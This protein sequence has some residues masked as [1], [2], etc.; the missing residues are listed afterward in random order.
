LEAG[1]EWL[2]NLEGCPIHFNLIQTTSLS[3]KW[4]W[5]NTKLVARSDVFPFKGPAKVGGPRLISEEKLQNRRGQILSFIGTSGLS[6]TQKIII[7]VVPFISLCIL[8]GGIW[9]SWRIHWKR[10][11]EREK[12]KADRNMGNDTPQELCGDTDM[13]RH[14]IGVNQIPVEGDYDSYLRELE[15]SNPAAKELDSPDRPAVELEGE[16]LGSNWRDFKA[17]P[18]ITVDSPK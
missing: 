1:I 2:K 3:G 14:E 11:L 4:D 18:V 13:N 15:D 16:P 17:I 10:K 5:S 7:G 12:A 8:I 9:R 6:N